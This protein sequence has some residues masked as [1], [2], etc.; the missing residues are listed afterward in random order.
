M[1]RLLFILLL[2]G[3]AHAQCPPTRQPYTVAITTAA[4]FAQPPRLPANSGL[5]TDK[6]GFTRSG[7]AFLLQLTNGHRK[8]LLRKPGRTHEE[9]VA[10]LSYL[11]ILP[12][13]HKYVLHVLFWE[14]SRILL[15]DQ[16]TGA[17]DSLQA[18][19]TLSPKVGFVATTFQGYP[20]KGAPNGVEVFQVAT[21]HVR[22]KFTI[23]QEQWLPYGLAWVD[24][25]SFIVKCLPLAVQEL[26]ESGKLS[27]KVLQNSPRFFYLRVTMR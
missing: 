23:A 26:V 2:A 15:V 18:V 4:A 24:E 22:R 1:K 12:C 21:S 5:I 3:M 27:K 8:R 10:E 9:D 20:Y 13:L 25:H 11:G 6:Q 14:A 17:I 16:Q 19:P 7:D